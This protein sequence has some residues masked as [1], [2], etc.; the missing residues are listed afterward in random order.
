MSIAK[1]VAPLLPYLRRFSASAERVASKW[2]RLSDGDFGRSRGKTGVLCARSLPA[3]R[4]LSGLPRHVV[5]HARRH[6]WRSLRGGVRRSTAISLAFP[7]VRAPF[8][9]TTV[10]DSRSRGLAIMGLD[11]VRVRALLE[12]GARDLARGLAARFSIIEDE[13]IIAIGPRDHRRGP[14][15]QS[16]RGGARP[17][18]GGRPC[19]RAQ[20]SAD[21]GGHPAR[22]RRLGTR[23]GRRESLTTASKPVVFITAHP[24][25]YLSASLNRPEPASIL[26]KPFSPDSVRAAVCKAL[27]FDR[28]AR[29]AA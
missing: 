7:K 23:G 20:A 1:G 10:E 8:L 17:P 21:H 19:G 24:E 12:R 3:R 15:T 5:A 9:L 26:S 22:R 25:K 11:T 28:R 29:Q 4:A 18:A 14:R 27:F 6:L 2:R 13:P 16:S